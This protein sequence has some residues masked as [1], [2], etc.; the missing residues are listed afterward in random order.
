VYTDP[1]VDFTIREQKPGRGIFDAWVQNIGQGP[2]YDIRFKIVPVSTDEKSLKILSDL[3]KNNF[4]SQGINYLSPKQSMDTFLTWAYNDT[5][6]FDLKFDV[7][8]TYAGQTGEKTEDT[9]R[10]DMAEREGGSYV[11]NDPLS[12]IKKCLHTISKCME[13][14]A[15]GKTSISVNIVNEKED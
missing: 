14:F 11:N 4:I 13:K 15:D 8:V 12:D 6:C 7:I 9:Y 3:E 10:V 5:G 2:A 1:K